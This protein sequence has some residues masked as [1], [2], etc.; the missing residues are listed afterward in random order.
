M[1]LYKKIKLSGGLDR[2][3]QDSITNYDMMFKK[4]KTEKGEKVTQEFFDEIGTKIFDTLKASDY[5]IFGKNSRLDYRM[6]MTDGE[7][8]TTLVDLFFGR[9][10]ITGAKK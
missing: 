8:K 6:F 7:W 5:W 4:L 2:S 1:S 3:V 10:P 9:N